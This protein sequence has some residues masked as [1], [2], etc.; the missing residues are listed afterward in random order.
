MFADLLSREVMR[1]CQSTRRNRNHEDDVTGLANGQD[2]RC[3][4]HT[5]YNLP[6]KMWFDFKIVHIRATNKYFIC[7]SS[8]LEVLN[9]IPFPF[10]EKPYRIAALDPGVQ[11]FQTGFDEAGT[12]FEFGSV[13][14]E[15]RILRLCQ[16]LDT[17]E[18]RR[19]VKQSSNS[20]RFLLPHKRRASMK[21]AAG[22]MRERIQ[23]L[24]DELHQKA[25]L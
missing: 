21:H 16:H 10:Q 5:C 11:T 23:N 24:V 14:D 2:R 6:A 12:A 4:G 25:S 3:M 18:S 17:L 8:S 13:K 20:K 19:K 9:L 22:Q 7:I 15:R 1:I